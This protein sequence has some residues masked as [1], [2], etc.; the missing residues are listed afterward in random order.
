[1]D[2]QDEC[3]PSKVKVVLLGDSYAG[4]TSIIDNY[5]NKLFN[6]FYKVYPL[7]LSQQHNSTSPLKWYKGTIKKYRLQLWDSAGQERF[8]S[9]ASNFTKNAD[10]LMVIFDVANP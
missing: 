8:Y 7:T 10:V 2:S 6:S 4:K 1:M 3:L 5:I 9:L